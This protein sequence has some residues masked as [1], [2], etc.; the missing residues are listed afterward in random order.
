MADKVYKSS[1]YYTEEPDAAEQPSSENPGNPF[2][3]MNFGGINFGEM[4]A[5]ELSGLRDDFK[6][7]FS[8]VKDF[9]VRSTLTVVGT[10]T[11]VYIGFKVWRKFAKIKS[12]S[13]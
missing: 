3:G 8:A 13:K 10:M 5:N 11:L 9:P 12:R 7:V 1:D 6:N 4:A 2:M